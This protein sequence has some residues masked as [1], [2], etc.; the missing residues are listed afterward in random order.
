MFFPPSPA[1]FLLQGAAGASRPHPGALAGAKQPGDAPVAE[2]NAVLSPLSPAVLP[3][4]ASEGSAAAGDL[5]Q[6][7][8]GQ[9]EIASP[10]PL[11]ALPAPAPGWGVKQ[12][13]P[14]LVNSVKHWMTEPSDKSCC[15][16]LSS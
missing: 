2:V 14:R 10:P 11:P 1:R 6:Q 5:L 3:P 16:P 8:L 7:L 4:A 9:G 13:G 15:S 12:G